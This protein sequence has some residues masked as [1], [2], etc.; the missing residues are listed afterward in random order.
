MI[1]TE[2]NRKTILKE[3]PSFYK[4]QDVWK[5]RVNDAAVGVI[6]NR[7]QQVWSLRGFFWLFTL[8]L[9]FLLDKA[10]QYPDGVLFISAVPEVA[11][12]GKVAVSGAEK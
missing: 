11:N 1:T 12:E 9:S 4:F 2:K 6:G 8:L 5:A 10:S 3:V 7:T